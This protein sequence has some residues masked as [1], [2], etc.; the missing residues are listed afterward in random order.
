MNILKTFLF[1]FILIPAA[2]PLLHAQAGKNLLKGVRRSGTVSAYKTTETARRITEAVRLQKPLFGKPV[3]TSLEP[4]IHRFIFTVTPRGEINGFKGSG[5]VFAD[6]RNGKTVLWGA[7]AAHTVR[8]MGKEV[9]VS[10]RINGQEISFPATV[11]LTGRKFGLN[12]ALIKL[13]EEVAEVAL[14]FERAEEGVSKRTPVF[15]YGFSAGQ[16]KKT[17]REIL[18]PGADRLLANFPYF[19]EPKPGFCGSVVVNEQGRAIGI[20]TGGYDAATAPWRQQMQKDFPRLNFARVSEIV[21]IRQLDVLLKE[22]YTP[23][24]AKRVIL[25]SGM[26]V[27]MLDVNEYIAR[28]Y[29]RYQDGSLRIFDRS[30]L[31]ETM[32]MDNFLPDLD[33]ANT[34][35]LVI[36]QNRDRDYF[37]TINLKT[38][39][40]TKEDL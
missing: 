8:H 3:L 28:I 4:N 10:F 7:S 33:K 18:F 19:G 14:P 29:V 26:R 5:F 39:T 40:V 9:T 22:Y 27:G 16:Y 25:F 21:P 6:Q 20:E 15:T 23:H 34:V 32:A 11:E 35:S 36:N 38:R 24:S 17:Q 12:A 30:P 13:P 37:Y 1:I 2:G 31:W